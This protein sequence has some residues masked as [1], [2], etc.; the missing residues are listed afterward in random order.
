[1]TAPR[2]EVTTPDFFR[3]SGDGLLALAIEETLGL[4]L[5]LELFKGDL[6]RAGALGLE[7]LGHELELA[8]SFIEGDPSAGDDL[9]AVLRAELQQA[10]L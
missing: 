1:M 5:F 10:R 2:G 9:E 7:I 8:A 4:Q 6:E 3:E